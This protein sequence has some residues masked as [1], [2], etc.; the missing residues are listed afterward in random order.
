VSVLLKK[1]ITLMNTVDLGVLLRVKV[2]T[3]MTQA[4][5]LSEQDKRDILS[6]LRALERT[7]TRIKAAQVWTHMHQTVDHDCGECR[8]L[9]HVMQ[10]WD[11]VPS[12]K[13]VVEQTSGPRVIE[14]VPRCGE[15]VNC[16]EVVSLNRDRQRIGPFTYIT[17]KQGATM[18]VYGEP[19]DIAKQIWPER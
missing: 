8:A 17:F 15:F 9:R 6:V 7:D 12:L 1:K 11:K 5:T 14:L 4:Y 2:L 16:D 10:A 19:A 3:E 13:N 18:C